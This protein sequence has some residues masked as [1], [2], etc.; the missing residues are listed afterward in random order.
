[1]SIR[2]RN[3]L[4]ELM[5]YLVIFA[6]LFFVN[7]FVV[8]LVGVSGVSMEH[9]LKD[10]DQMLRWK[11]SSI[12]RFDIVIFPSPT[13]AVDENNE[14]KLYIKRVIGMPGDSLEFKNDKL[15]INGVE[16]DEPYLAEKLEEASSHSGTLFTRNFTLEEKTGT[17]IIP[18]GK[19][20]VMGDNRNRSVDSEEFGFVDIEKVTEAR[21]IIF[22]LEHFGDLPQYQLNDEGTIV[23]KKE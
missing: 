20:F 1:M 18:E 15:I 5:L 12:E 22:P 8:D 2:I 13:G 14:I 6:S 11:L 19:L 16:T 17:T 4:K 9:T 10:G 7:I 3:V 23:E 21:Y